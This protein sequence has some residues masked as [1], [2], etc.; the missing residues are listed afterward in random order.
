MKTDQSTDEGRIALQ[1]ETPL[2][3]SLVAELFTRLRALSDRPEHPDRV[4]NEL[5]Y[6]TPHVKK[7]EE[8]NLDLATTAGI[9]V[10]PNGQLDP[11]AGSRA[12]VIIHDEE[13]ATTAAEIPESVDNLE[14]ATDVNVEDVSDEPEDQIGSEE[15]AEQLPELDE[16]ESD[17]EGGESGV[18]L[19]TG[20]L[21]RM[22]SVCE[23]EDPDYGELQEIAKEL[24]SEGIGI[25]ANLS[26]DEFLAEFER[27]VDAHTPLPE[28]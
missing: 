1:P 9:S 2:E 11:D 16:S 12:L 14:P 26:T 7:F 25:A 10:T 4:G 22:E 24:Q 17:D 19:S 13:A 20:L 21:A 27:L 23:Q 8:L 28:P 3:Q 5:V 15:A 18:E 6:Y